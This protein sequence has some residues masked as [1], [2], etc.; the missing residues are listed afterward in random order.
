MRTVQLTLDE[1]LVDE[2]DRVAAELGTT[3]SAFARQALRAE[4][5]R[6]E[7]ADLEE[8]HRQ[9]YEAS[10]VDLSEVA[11]WEDEQVWPG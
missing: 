9:G 4:L 2:V 5:K 11:E 10:P 6:L 7:V 1:P 3:R 8:Q